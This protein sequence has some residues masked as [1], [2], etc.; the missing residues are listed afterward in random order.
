V[1]VISDSS[2]RLKLQDYAHKVSVSRDVPL[3]LPAF[4]SCQ[5]ILLVDTG[6]GA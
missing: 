1:S 3:Y 6:D 4:T 2:V 5:I